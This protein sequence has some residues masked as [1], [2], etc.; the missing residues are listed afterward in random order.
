MVTKNNQPQSPKILEN[1][2]SVPTIASARKQK[3]KDTFACFIDESQP[4]TRNQHSNVSPA[5]PHLVARQH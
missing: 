4:V 5:V 3:R 2:F 1:V